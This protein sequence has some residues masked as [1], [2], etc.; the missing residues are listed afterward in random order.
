ML[1]SLL[2]PP[3]LFVRAPGLGGLSP[4]Q[5][6]SQWRL[7]FSRIRSW[8]SQMIVGTYQLVIY[9]ERHLSSSANFFHASPL[10]VEEFDL[11]DKNFRPCPCGYQVRTPP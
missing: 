10:C 6:P 1:S 4:L 2:T 9:F 7:G 11:S 8:T 5:L 3:D